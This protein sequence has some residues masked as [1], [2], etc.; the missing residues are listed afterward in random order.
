MS[1]YP[2]QLYCQRLD[3]SQNMARYY[4]LSIQPTLFGEIAVMRSWGRIGNIGGEMMDVFDTE[5]DAAQHFLELAR[6]KRK[7][8]YRPVASCGNPHNC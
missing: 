7:K 6:R 2:Y 4:M 5:R 8:G 1:L 3:P